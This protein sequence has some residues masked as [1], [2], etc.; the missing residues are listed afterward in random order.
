MIVGYCKVAVTLHG[1]RSLKGKRK[2]ILSLKDKVKDRFNVSIAEVDH[3]DMHQS[4]VI[5]LGVVAADQAHADSQLQKAVGLI[6]QQAHVAN[7]S[8]EFITV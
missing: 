3:H 6:S 7:V 1:V 8:M 2:T 5:G 4:A